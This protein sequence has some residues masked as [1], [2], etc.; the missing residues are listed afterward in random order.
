MKNENEKF[1]RINDRIRF[2]PI[3]VI[4]ESGKNLGPVPLIKAK[5]LANYAGLDLVEVSPNSRP[6]VCKI[7]DFGKF[8]Y[9]QE[10]KDKKQRQSKKFTQTKEIR[11][12]CGIADNDLETKLK[13]A[14]KFLHAGSKVNVRLEFKRRENNHTEIGF[15]VINKFCSKLEEFGTIGRKP[16]LDGRF[17]FCLV[18]PNK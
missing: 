15:S 8:K 7:M 12:S 6:P 14:I 9:Q 2:S 18:E 17:L 4:D 10:I 11:L 13:S 1:Y 16:S 3:V 5:E